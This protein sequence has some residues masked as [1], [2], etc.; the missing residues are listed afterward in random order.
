MTS[1][2]RQTEIFEYLKQVD[3]ASVSALADLFHVSEMTIRRDLT[4][5]EDA[6]LIIRKHGRAVLA[7]EEDLSIHF[8]IRS[9]KNHEK[10]TIIAQRTVP[11]L[12]KAKIL[13]FD[14]SSSAFCLLS[15]L[16]QDQEYTI[17]TNSLAIFQEICKMPNIRPFIIGGFLT[18]DNNTLDDETSRDVAKHIYVDVAVLS[19]YGFSH[20]GLFNNAYTGT[21][22]KRIIQE[23][24][25][26]TIVLADSTKAFTRGI[27]LFS[28]WGSINYLVTDE[29]I[30][31]GLK[32]TICKYSV[33][34]IDR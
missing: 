2:K 30:S 31:E 32:N 5:L 16:P 1:R 4:A 33:T 24:A 17:Y 8:A 11:L 19:C 7:K 15:Y 27:Y 26:E 13:Y 28:S 14:G 22:V 6:S 34:I 12:K 3:S 10:K 21:D 9:T 25:V 20:E 29:A 18:E 23:N